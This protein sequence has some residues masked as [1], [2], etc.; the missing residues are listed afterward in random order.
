MYEF[1]YG[2]VVDAADSTPLDAM[3]ALEQLAHVW[4]LRGDVAA[5]GHFLDRILRILQIDSAPTVDIE[6]D[7]SSAAEEE[8]EMEHRIEALNVKALYSCLLSL[9]SFEHPAAD[10]AR[11]RMKSAVDLAAD[12][13]VELGDFFGARHPATFGLNLYFGLHFVSIEEMHCAVGHIDYVVA[14]SHCA[15]AKEHDGKPQLDALKTRTLQFAER[16]TLQDLLSL[17]TAKLLELEQHDDAMKGRIL[18]L[19]GDQRESADELNRDIGAER[20]RRQKARRER[21]AERKEAESASPRRRMK[22]EKE[23][24]LSAGTA[25]AVAVAV[26]E[27]AVDI[28]D[29]DLSPIDVV[30][31]VLEQH[32]PLMLQFGALDAAKA[33]MDDLESDSLPKLTERHCVVIESL[34]TKWAAMKEE[35]ARN[36]DVEAVHSVPSDRGMDGRFHRHLDCDFEGIPQ[37]MPTVT[38]CSDS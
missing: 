22:A 18:R 4:M 38:T 13:L 27:V 23:E 9:H 30:Q 35:V 17:F 1:A 16:R 15:A 33:A 21:A 28:E 25:V 37:F 14:R 12:C 8:E 36:G 11:R 34:R 20:A 7:G 24:A 19:F 29:A 5:S 31:M 26:D 10:G 6:V 32:I 2:L 3:V